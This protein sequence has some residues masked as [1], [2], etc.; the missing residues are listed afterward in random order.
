MAQA[1][2][3]VLH[4]KHDQVSYNAAGIVQDARAS[5][6]S[7]A[8]AAAIQK[9]GAG[10]RAACSMILYQRPPAAALPSVTSPEFRSNQALPSCSAKTVVHAKE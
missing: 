5:D 10:C 9:P 1:V 3:L 4:Q 7:T 2:R 8:P 6:P